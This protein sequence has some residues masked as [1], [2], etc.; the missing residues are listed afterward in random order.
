MASSSW[1]P[2]KEFDLQTFCTDFSSKTT[3]SPTTCSLSAA[4][5]TALAAL[6]TAYTTALAATDPATET[7]VTVAA[8]NTAKL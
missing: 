1:L 7:K 6:V 8:K 3:A 5:A 4:D 2:L